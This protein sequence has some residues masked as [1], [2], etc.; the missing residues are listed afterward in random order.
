MNKEV[1]LHLMCYINQYKPNKQDYY[2]Q[3]EIQIAS[4]KY[5]SAIK[6]RDYCTYKRDLFVVK[7]I[8]NKRGIYE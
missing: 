4:N 8:L 7:E 1:A 2:L 3:K 6:A 5:I